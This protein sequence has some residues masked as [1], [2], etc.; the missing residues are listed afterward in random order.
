M[1]PEDV[2]EFLRKQ[3]FQPFWLALTDG[4]TYEIC[5]P[6]LIMVGK[7]S[8]VVGLLRPGDV[9][10]IY[11]RAVTVSFLHIMQIEPL[12]SAAA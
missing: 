9:E 7:S 11:D 12:E 2:R 10:P 3:P 1:R 5:H 8:A 4:R 6:E